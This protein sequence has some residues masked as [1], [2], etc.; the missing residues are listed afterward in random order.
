M[1]RLRSLH[2]SAQG[3]SLVELMIVV[4]IAAVLAAVGIPSFQTATAN[5]RAKAAAQA[6]FITFQQARTEAVG[7]NGIC[8]V[9][10][11]PVDSDNWN[12]GWEIVADNPGATTTCSYDTDFNGTDDVTVNEPLA[13]WNAL[14]DIVITVPGAPASID[15]DKRGRIS[16]ALGGAIIVCDDENR[17]FEREV[18]IDT[19]GLP[20]IRLSETKC[21]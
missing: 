4:L 21:S 1:N 13:Q 10:I 11:E 9:S 6:L 2:L 18:R 19:S 20:E 14:E 17:T 12:Q 3:F 7:F 16:A 8:D 5:A 15:Y